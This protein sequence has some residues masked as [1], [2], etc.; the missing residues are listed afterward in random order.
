MLE[1]VAAQLED[2]GFTVLT[3]AGGTEAL[4][5]LEEGKAVQALVSDLSTGESGESFI[6]RLGLRESYRPTRRPSASGAWS[7]CRKLFVSG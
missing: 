5:M 4:A 3:A 1:T 2:E 7:P 6:R